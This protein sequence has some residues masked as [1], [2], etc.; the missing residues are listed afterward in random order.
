MK[1]GRSL[2]ANDEKVVAYYKTV[3]EAKRDEEKSRDQA[4]LLIVGGALTL[5]FQLVASLLERRPLIAI[6]W[7]T[8]A[9]IVWSLALM[10][11]LINY[12]LSISSHEHILNKLSAGT[13]DRASLVPKSVKWIPVL[14]QLVTAGT[15]AGFFLFGIFALRNLTEQDPS[16]I[17]QPREA[18]D[19]EKEGTDKKETEPTSHVSENSVS[20]TNQGDE[21]KARLQD[22]DPKAP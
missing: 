1:R 9:W 3:Q 20:P 8:A 17:A 11:T 16:A 2:D 10:G 6:G 4:V 13:Y 14:N 21:A 19:E 12:S 18:A 5:S 15:V 22:S 7:L